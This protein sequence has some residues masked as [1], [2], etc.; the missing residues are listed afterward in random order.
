MVR[1]PAR[2]LV[3]LVS[4]RMLSSG[5]V[6][7]LPSATVAA[8]VRVLRPQSVLSG[9]EVSGVEVDVFP[10]EPE[11]FSLSQAQREG[12]DPAGAVAQLRGLQEEALNLLDRVGLDVLFFQARGPGDLGRIGGDV[13]APYCLAE[14]D[15][16]R[17]VHV[18]PAVPAALPFSYISP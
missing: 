1:R 14:G 7:G 2:D 6:A 5:A 15:A 10:H 4:R 9:P 11:C 18:M 13:P 12:D 8:A 16:D 17:A 3:L